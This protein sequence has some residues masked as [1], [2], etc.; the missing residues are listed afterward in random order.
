MDIV[1]VGVTIGAQKGI[2]WAFNNLKN[3]PLPFKQRWSKSLLR[4]SIS[5]LHRICIKDNN[6][7]THYLL[8][9]NSRV[10]MF[11]PPGGVYKYYDKRVLETMEA[12]DDQSFHEE[13]DLRIKLP[14]RNLI[15][16]LEALKNETW[17]ES[18]YHRE[19]IEE[20]IETK[21]LPIELFNSPKFRFVERKNSKL[22]WSDHFQ[23]EE[24]I[25]YDIID[26]ILNEKQKK[27]LCKMLKESSSTDFIFASA[28]AIKRR[29]FCL[30]NNKDKVRI[31]EHTKVI[32]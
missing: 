10:P 2:N 29:G 5:Y 25:F 17:R 19:Y 13:G 31:S 21:I 16:L 11:Q 3:S 32:L 6:G 1:Q 24:I 30:K 27:H 4:V 14:K 23:C 20:L 18:S 12:K 9:K 28:N 7:V 15:N 8:V 22:R 26:V